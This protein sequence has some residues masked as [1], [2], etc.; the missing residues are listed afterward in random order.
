MKDY[1]YFFMAIFTLYAILKLID[2][3]L[4]FS[5]DCLL[6][7]TGIQRNT[8]IELPVPKNGEN[9]VITLQTKNGDNKPTKEQEEIDQGKKRN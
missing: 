5:I 7:W 9:I 8:S 1:A 4:S 2:I 3:G 6:R